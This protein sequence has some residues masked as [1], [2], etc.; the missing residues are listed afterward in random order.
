M[1]LPHDLMFALAQARSR[2]TFWVYLH[3]N[4]IILTVWSRPASEAN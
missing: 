4:G 2:G 3:L 1:E